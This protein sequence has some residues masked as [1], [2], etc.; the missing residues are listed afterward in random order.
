MGFIWTVPAKIQRS[1]QSLIVMEQPSQAEIERLIIYEQIR[2]SA[3]AHYIKNPR[4]ADV[5]LF[6]FLPLYL[7]INSLFSLHLFRYLS[8]FF[9]H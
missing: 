2:M 1:N 3:E 7:F 4:D 9:T 6:S 8:S 5:S